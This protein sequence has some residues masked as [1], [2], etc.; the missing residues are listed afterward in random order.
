MRPGEPHRNHRLLPSPAGMVLL[1]PPPPRQT[2]P[3]LATVCSFPPLLWLIHSLCRLPAISFPPSFKHPLILKTQLSLSPLQPQ[4]CGHTWTSYLTL[5]SRVFTPGFTSH[6]YLTPCAHFWY[7]NVIFQSF[8]S[9]VKLMF[10][11]EPWSLACNRNRQ[12][13]K[14]TVTTTTKTL[15]HAHV[16]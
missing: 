8:W 12:A 7:L 4:T 11:V 1:G 13:F 6:L 3:R 16:L 10:L 5:H 15:Y 2:F 9:S 14:I